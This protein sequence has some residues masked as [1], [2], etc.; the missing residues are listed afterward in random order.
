MEWRVRGVKERSGRERS[1]TPADDAESGEDELERT[2]DSRDENS[3]REMGGGAVGV[4]GVSDQLQT[5]VALE[6]YSKM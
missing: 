6:I 4:N 5:S 3:A 2:K 1:P